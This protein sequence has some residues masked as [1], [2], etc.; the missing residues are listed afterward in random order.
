MAGMIWG[1]YSSEDR[2]FF[3]GL[4]LIL[5]PFITQSFR[6]YTLEPR[7]N[8]QAA[9]PEPTT[10]LEAPWVAHLLGYGRIT[11]LDRATV[12]ESIQ[13][14]LVFADET[15]EITY[16]FSD[17]MGILSGDKNTDDCLAF[18]WAVIRVLGSIK[19]SGGRKHLAPQPPY[20]D[21]TPG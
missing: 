19:A 18:R 13:Q 21:I 6:P 7:R 4:L 12:A 10:I 14:I 8:T 1:V 15:I 16:R 11:E 3:R 5:D 20:D 17:N 2:F 9:Q